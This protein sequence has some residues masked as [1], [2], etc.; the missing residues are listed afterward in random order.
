LSR[1]VVLQPQEVCWTIAHVFIKNHDR[2]CSER[3]GAKK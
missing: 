2:Y 1:G 3:T